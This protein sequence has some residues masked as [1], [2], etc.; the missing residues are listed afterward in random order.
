M[1]NQHESE[2][3]GDIG[4]QQNKY[5]DPRFFE[6]YQRMP[7]S[8]E[9]LSA[10]GEWTQLRAMLGD[11]KDKRVLDL[12]CGF[13][14]HC[15]YARE[16]EARTVL[17]VDLSAKMLERA[18]MDTEDPAIEYRQLAIEDIDFDMDAFD[19]VISSVALHYV[20]DFA[21][22]CQ[23]VARSLVPGGHFVFSVE[24][25]TYTADAAQDWCYGPEGTRRH[26]IFDHYQE[27]GARHT[28]FLDED[29]VK[30]HRTLATYVNGVLG[31]GFRIREI[32][33]SR[34]TGAMLDED[35]RASEES[36]R[37][38]FLLVAAER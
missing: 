36:R 10:A 18:R 24:H 8:I 3:E 23:R 32:Q 6:K 20:Q 26:W 2:T 11:L 28:R 16:Q 29:V 14:W 12:G 25:P 27:E 22:V 33:E 31:T 9:G 30:Y 37:P 35:P 5:D 34:A 38:M 17:G 7:R 13:G 4:L 19:V 1:E 15:R 21:D